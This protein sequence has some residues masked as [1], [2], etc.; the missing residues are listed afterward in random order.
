MTTKHDTEK[1]RYDLLPPE[2]IG[3]MA[4]VLTFGAKKYAPNNWRTIPDALNRYQAAMLRHAFAIQRGEIN[5]PETGLP[6]AA[7]IMCCAAFIVELQGA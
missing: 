2:A 3:Q 7:H 4:Q 6:H 5:D 1:P